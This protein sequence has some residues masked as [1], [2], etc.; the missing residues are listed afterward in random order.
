MKRI[1]L[2]VLIA[3]DLLLLAAIVALWTV[4]D[5]RWRVPAAHPPDAASL[6][7]AAVNGRQAPPP[8]VADSVERPLFASS[9]RPPGA[10]EGG[11][12][13]GE[14]GGEIVVLGTFDAGGADKGVVLRVDGMDYRIRLGESVG[15][16]RL[17][18]VDGRVATFVNG[19][20][21]REIALAHLPQPDEAAAAESSRRPP[22]GSRVRPPAGTRPDSRWRT[23]N[24]Q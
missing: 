21:R 17:E 14:G 10:T 16:W 9:R 5:W 4:R 18:A 22:G 8:V 24:D 12:A 23:P 19:D 1:A 2:P 7:P 3:V 11:A 20:E 15:A 6:A 13:A